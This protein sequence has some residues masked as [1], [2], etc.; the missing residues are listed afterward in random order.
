[1]YSMYPIYFKRG[2]EDV[3]VVLCFQDVKEGKD[4]YVFI[5]FQILRICLKGYM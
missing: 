3:D 5:C 1:M 4:V 2:W